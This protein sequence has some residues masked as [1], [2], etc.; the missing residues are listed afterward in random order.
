MDPQ[1]KSDI[2]ASGNKK[3]IDLSKA[4]ISGGTTDGS[5]EHVSVI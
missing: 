3:C 5:T 1:I 4:E 2:V